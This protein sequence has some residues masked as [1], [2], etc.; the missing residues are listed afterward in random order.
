MPPRADSN[1]L[2]K[3]ETAHI[4][5]AVEDYREDQRPDGFAPSTEFDVLDDT[6]R[7]PPEQ[8]IGL[9]GRQAYG[10]SLKPSE[11][12]GGEDSKCA[13]LIIEAGYGFVT[14]PQAI[15]SFDATFSVGRDK[16]GYFVIC[17]S[18]GPNRNTHYSPGLEALLSAMA[19]LDSELLSASVESVNTLKELSPSARQIQMEDYPYPVKLRQL[20]SIDTLRRSLTRG[21]AAIGRSG[22]RQRGGGNSTKRLKLSFHPKGQPKLAELSARFGSG[23]PCSPSTPPAFN[24]QAS[25]PSHSDPRSERRA[26][27]ST[28]VT[29][30]H[31][32]LQKALYDTLV[33][34]FGPDA[35]AA[36]QVMACGKP[37]D[38][39]VQRP[40]GID[41]YEIK[42][43]VI[44]GE[45]VRQALGQLLEYGYAGEGPP[46]DTL[47]VVGPRA[48]DAAT[49]TYLDKLRSRFN[50]PIYYRHQPEDDADTSA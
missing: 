37:S 28:L 45:C 23:N 34:E 48:C 27:A 16:D 5:Q 15:G 20:A 33:E 24:F 26:Q 36:E 22:E 9:A 30:V 7:Y 21:S 6:R 2:A 12:S 4:H 14:K 3:I 18:R 49:E 40:S 1:N 38:L 29:H 17:E 39:V 43:S 10:R 25:A 41:I 13:R 50:L 42:T 19:D 47:W 44:P 31:V 11:F 35:V 46:V 8:I 32:T